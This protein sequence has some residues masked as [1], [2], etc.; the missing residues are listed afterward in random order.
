MVDLAKSLISTG[1]ANGLAFPSKSP[2][3]KRELVT[4]SFPP[5]PLATTTPVT[6][7]VTSISGSGYLLFVVT[8]NPCPLKSMGCVFFVSG[9]INTSFSHLTL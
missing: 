5:E 3:S 1:L 4:K 6:V 2:P 7:S 9:S 8:S